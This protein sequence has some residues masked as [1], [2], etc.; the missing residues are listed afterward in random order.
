MSDLVGNDPT[1]KQELLDDV[2]TVDG[3]HDVPSQDSVDNAQMRD[4]IGNKTDTHDGDSL[5]AVAHL[6]SEHIHGTVLIQPNL[7]G[8]ITLTS[9]AGA[10]AAMNATKTQIIAAGAI[11][12]DFDLHFM[13]IAAISANGEYQIELYKGGIG[14]EISIGNFGAVRNAVQSQEGSRPILTELLPANTRISAALSS[15]NAGADTLTIK[16]EGHT[17]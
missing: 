15:S 17:Y 9:D 8:S 5:R 11:T 2:E 6:I 13:N 4:V 10:W 7:A 12:E 3:F 1:G 16:L 14:A